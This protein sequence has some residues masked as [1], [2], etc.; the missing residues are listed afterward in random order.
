M[1]DTNTFHEASNKR[2][3]EILLHEIQNLTSIDEILRPSTDEEGPLTVFI[4]QLQTLFDT[5]EDSVHAFTTILETGRQFT[6]MSVNDEAHGFAASFESIV[7]TLID[8]IVYYM[9]TGEELQEVIPPSPGE[10][11]QAF[12]EA[13]SSIRDTEN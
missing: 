2:F 9:F 4:G 6:L 12:I 7:T 3:K 11:A 5:D 10:V 1:T 8:T 13:E